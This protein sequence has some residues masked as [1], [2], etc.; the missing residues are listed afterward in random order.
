LQAIMN[1][2]LADLARMPR[3]FHHTLRDAAAAAGTAGDGLHWCVPPLQIRWLMHYVRGLVF[4]HM[5][6][7]YHLLGNREK[8]AEVYQAQQRDMQVS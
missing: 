3:M 8:Q 2:L 4:H 1:I 5:G 7:V 6:A